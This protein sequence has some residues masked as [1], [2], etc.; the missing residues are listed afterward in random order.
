MK[1]LFFVTLIL[2]LAAWI[3]A[4]EAR[5]QCVPEMPRLAGSADC[6]R[7]VLSWE[8]NGENVKEF[9]ISRDGEHF[10]I[11]FNEL[12]EWT[13][14]TVKEGHVYTYCLKAKGWQGE[15][16]EACVTLEIPICREE[17]E[18]LEPSYFTGYAIRYFDESE[19]RFKYYVLLDWGIE[20][21]GSPGQWELLRVVYKN[22]P[23]TGLPPDVL[24]GKFIVLNTPFFD[25]RV[26]AHGWDDHNVSR[27]TTIFYL[28]RWRC[29][30]CRN[31]TYF[32]PIRVEVPRQ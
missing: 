8:H 20:G 4:Q 18:E 31:W 9:R 19:G 1:K 15:S 7:A 30:P 24:V 5:I 12:R 14:W 29:G 17:C 28:L 23:E 25:G 32:G 27:N 13:D 22:D 2:C 3:G 11:V 26:T 10:V 6:R 16:E 21:P